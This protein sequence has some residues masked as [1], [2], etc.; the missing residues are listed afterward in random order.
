MRPAEN[1]T[2]RAFVLI[3][4]A[5]IGIG[6]KGGMALTP[7]SCRSPHEALLRIDKDAPVLVEHVIEAALDN[8]PSAGWY[9]IRC[10][11]HPGPPGRR[12]VRSPPRDK[13]GIRQLGEVIDT[14]YRH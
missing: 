1:E 10:Y 5:V 3:V 14:G 8:T 4:V 12:S 11:S 13:A 9:L 6:P 7:R 2:G